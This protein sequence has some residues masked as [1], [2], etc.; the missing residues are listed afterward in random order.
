SSDL[1]NSVSS[2]GNIAFIVMKR[3]EKVGIPLNLISFDV[4]ISLISLWQRVMPS[5]L[6]WNNNIITAHGKLNI[7]LKFK[8]QTDIKEK[9]SY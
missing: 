1:G 8:V 7:N 2:I 5:Y 9:Y 6:Q 4:L 3:V